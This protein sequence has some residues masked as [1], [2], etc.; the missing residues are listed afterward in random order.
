M[1]IIGIFMEGPNTGACLFSNGKLVAMAEEERFIRQKTASERFPSNSI[2]FCLKKAN[3]KL[4]D[5]H[6]VATAWDHD[7]YPGP[8]DE[9]MSSLPGRDLDPL[10]HRAE[11]IIHNKLAP[12]LARF[13]IKTGLKKID[14]EANPN[15][16]WYSHH[17]AH[18]ASVH[19]LSGFEESAVLVMDGSGENQAS[20]TWHGNG[21][22][23]NLVNEWKLPHSLGWFYSALTEWLGFKA[24]S[25]E[26][27][28]MGLAAYGK[29]SPDFAKKLEKVCYLNEEGDYVVDPTYIYFGERTY[30]RKFT[31]KLVD[32]LGP[33]RQAETELN[34]FY[35]DAAYE[36]QKV[37]EKISISITKKLISYLKTSNLCVSGGVA[38]NCKMNGLLSNLEGI[39]NI[40][41]NPA[42]HDSG[43]ALGAALLAYKDLGESPRRDKLDH[44][45]WGPEFTD[46]EIEE[47]L[48]HCNLKYR[49]VDDISKECAKLLNE[50]KIIGWFQ[51]RAEFGARA[52]GSRSIIANPTNKDMKDIV[53]A[54]VK[55]REG[56]RPFAPSMIEEVKDKY[57]ENPKDS[58][59]MILAYQ[60]KEEFKDIFPSVVHVDGSVRPQTVSKKYNERYWNLINEFGNISGHPIIINTSF[61]VRGEPIVNTP[62]DAIRCFF[63]TG[64]DAL[65]IGSY[66]IVKDEL[67]G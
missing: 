55:Y 21:D 26:G 57:M 16:K 39:E 38:M 66:I 64:M 42:S 65:A 59:F 47:K 15:I 40:F 9:Y 58:P 28:V 24:Y 29:S 22:E 54:R 17:K 44:A 62:L 2:S 48:K 1:N 35:I 12:D 49:K 34:D 30:S 10:A 50:S 52:L 5:I 20:T 37:L 32:L 51:G 18:A 31:D 53:N 61:N 8:M 56:F 46:E 25:G 43:T 6:T 13:N 41:I 3:L 60:F 67:N 23:L 19:Y 14:P 33:P 27:K 63:S 11:T 4:T 7:F 45:Y 36:T